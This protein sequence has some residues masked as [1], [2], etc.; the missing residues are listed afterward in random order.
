MS[1]NPRT[2]SFR[3]FLRITF[4]DVTLLYSSLLYFSLDFIG[5]HDDLVLGDVIRHY[6]IQFSNIRSH[7]VFRPIVSERKYLIDYN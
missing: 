4:C 6:H 5:E 2:A 1:L 3:Y 7:D